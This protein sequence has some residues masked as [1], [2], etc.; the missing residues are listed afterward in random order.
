MRM[1]CA[2]GSQEL[3]ADPILLVRNEMVAA[4]EYQKRRIS[5]SRLRRMCVYSDRSVCSIRPC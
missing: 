1:E 5:I 3:V 2:D 4:A